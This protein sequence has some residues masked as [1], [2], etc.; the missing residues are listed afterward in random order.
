MTSAP[1][2]LFDRFRFL[3]NDYILNE[4]EAFASE[5]DD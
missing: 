2:C 3:Q 4:T 5:F 1:L